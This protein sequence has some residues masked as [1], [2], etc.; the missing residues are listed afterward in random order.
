MKIEIYKV[1]TGNDIQPNDIKLEPII[2]KTTTH[3][4]FVILDLSKARFTKDT[5]ISS[6]SDAVKF[7]GERATIENAIAYIQ[8]ETNITLEFELIDEMSITEN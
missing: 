3:S 2:T 4:G 8:E 6:E 1:K 7:I 5:S